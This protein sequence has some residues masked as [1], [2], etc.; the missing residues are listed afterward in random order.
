MGLERTELRLGYIPL[1]DAAPLY[2][3]APEAHEPRVRAVPRVPPRLGLL[4]LQVRAHR[5]LDV[6]GRRARRQP[7]LDEG[8]A[9][10]R[11]RYQL[12]RVRVGA[13]VGGFEDVER[14]ERLLR[15][16]AVGFVGEDVEV[17]FGS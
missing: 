1:N 2:R 10:A 17:R 7:Q 4:L 13:D 9:L 3:D 12:G 5:G 6:R 14:A 11:P 15:R 8:A 16:R